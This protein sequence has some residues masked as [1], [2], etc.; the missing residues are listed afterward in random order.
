MS[1]KRLDATIIPYNVA[2]DGA[3]IQSLLQQ[4]TGESSYMAELLQPIPTNSG[5]AITQLEA[6]EY[7]AGLYSADDLKIITLLIG[8]NDIMGTVIAGNG[9]QL[10]A[11]AINAF[12]EDT[13]KGHDLN[14]IKSNL[15]TIV[16]R[17]T[18]IP[19]SHIFIANIP[20]VTGIAGLFNAEDIQRLAIFD[21][22]T[23]TALGSGHYLGFG[24]VL[25]GLAPT[26]A[27]AVLT[28]NNTYLNGAIQQ[29]MSVDGYYLTA[30]EV[31][32]ISNRAAAI[33]SHINELV[34]QHSN[35]HLVDVVSMF[36]QILNG[37]IAIDGDTIDRG[38]SAGL[39][40]LDGFHPSNTGYAMIA[41]EFIKAINS[42]GIIGNAAQVDLETVW[43]NDPYRDKDGDGYVAGPGLSPDGKPIYNA[44]F[45]ALLDCNDNNNAVYSPFPAN[46]M[47]GQCQ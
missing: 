12:L 13:T 5:K 39:F 37:Q 33:S 4:T 19:N 36:D 22:P 42:T 30:E 3:T 40:S 47:T 15:N 45:T 17:L 11:D 26:Q 10:T 21:E 29:L 31:A 1:K 41:N 16:E 14:S 32:L 35:L 44:I 2:V 27:P 8:G 6:A 9:T 7:V 25:Q 46:G 43:A 20:S 34:S 24:P 28:M 38:Y 23:V 18:K